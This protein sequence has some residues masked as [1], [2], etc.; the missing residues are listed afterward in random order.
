MSQ[1]KQFLTLIGQNAKYYTTYTNNQYARPQNQK[2]KGLAQA[3][4]IDTDPKRQNHTLLFNQNSAPKGSTLLL[5]DFDDKAETNDQSQLLAA[6]AEYKLP[7]TLTIKTPTGAG[8][9]LYYLIPEKYATSI[10][11]IKLENLLVDNKLSN[12]EVKVATID[13]DFTT[14]IPGNVKTVNGEQRTYEFANPKKI[15]QASLLLLAYL[16]RMETFHF[17]KVRETKQQNE[18]KTNSEVDSDLNTKAAFEYFSRI[19]RSPFIESGKRNSALF[20]YFVEIF[21]HNI[22]IDYARA[23]FLPPLN[24]AARMQIPL[25]EEEAERC[26]T[27]AFRYV[28]EA[29]RYTE[30]S[31]SEILSSWNQDDYGFYDIP[32]TELRERARYLY[33]FSIHK[34][35][36]D[37]EKRDA[38]FSMII[39]TSNEYIV[40]V[41]YPKKIF[42]I[43]M[44]R[45]LQAEKPNIRAISDA[46]HSTELNFKSYSEKSFDSLYKYK[47]GKKN[48]NPS[49]NDSESFI[50]DIYRT[51]LF[52]Q[53][54]YYLKERIAYLA[55]KAIFK[56][57]DEERQYYE[58]NQEQHD[59]DLTEF[60]NLFQQQLTENQKDWDFLLDRLAGIVKDPNALIDNIPILEGDGGVGKTF[61][62]NVFCALFDGQ[63]VSYFNTFTQTLEKH[64]PV[65]LLNIIEELSEKDLKGAAL[66][67][68]K[69]NSTS[70]SQTENQK[71]RDI[72]SRPGRQNYFICTN[73]EM[74]NLELLKNRRITIFRSFTALSGSRA[75]NAIAKAKDFILGSKEFPFWGLKLFYKFLMDREIQ[76]ET[77]NYKT[78]YQ[79]QLIH[80]KIVDDQHIKILVNFVANLGLTNLK[81]YRYPITH[82]DAIEAKENLHNCNFITNRHDHVHF[83]KRYYENVD[84]ETP[85]TTIRN[86]R[87]LSWAKLNDI[88]LKFYHEFYDPNQKIKSVIGGSKYT[89]FTHITQPIKDLLTSFGPYMIEQFGL[90]EHYEFLKDK[91]DITY[92]EITSFLLEQYPDDIPGQI[93]HIQQISQDDF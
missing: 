49:V 8:R 57:N 41:L 83:F 73:H 23:R 70:E 10:P 68:L 60:I 22:S 76:R 16:D 53:S 4:V 47:V 33:Q 90:T 1:I 75:G 11:N 6:L 93:N 17:N 18:I 69:G 21:T 36:Q 71:Y 7:Q 5:L 63:H 81:D 37:R 38:F 80:N 34:I 48:Q 67:T 42:K 66:D 15:A 86:E 79:S 64:K 12:I 27:S 77:W 45:A 52:T 31:K 88:V 84:P 58:N 40:P 78:E 55:T 9:H 51:D 65:T 50:I 74:N 32:L 35:L 43:E 26:L 44:M 91:K 25:S 2:P 89:T 82:Q 56:L 87:F 46:Y 24:S 59:I 28:Q 30:R 62:I 13:S 19:M 14:P 39:K 72:T 54:E 20:G 92:E 3:T 61:F 29:G 85:F